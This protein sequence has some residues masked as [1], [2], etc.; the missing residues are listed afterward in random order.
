MGGYESTSCAYAITTPSSK[1][2]KLLSNVDERWDVA[3]TIMTI[4]F[5]L[6][7]RIL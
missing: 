1:G 4:P 2:T 5:E 7:A 3:Q 6:A